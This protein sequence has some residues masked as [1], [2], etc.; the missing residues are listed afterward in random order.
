M[1][2]LLCVRCEQEL[3]PSI[4]GVVVVEYSDLGPYKVWSA[5]EW[6]C[7]ICGATIVAGFA[8]LPY[9]REGDDGLDEHIAAVPSRILHKDFENQKQRMKFLWKARSEK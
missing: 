2:K 8:D 4:N 9:M 7:P 5:D 3:R 6:T 1:P